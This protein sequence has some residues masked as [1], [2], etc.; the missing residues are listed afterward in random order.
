MSKLPS[1]IIYGKFNLQIYYPS[2]YYRKVWYYYDA[3]TELIR[4]ALISLI[5]KRYF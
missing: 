4:H 2:Q 3:N 5:R 1:E